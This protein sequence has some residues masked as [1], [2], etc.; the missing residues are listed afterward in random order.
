MHKLNTKIKKND[1][2]DIFITLEIIEVLLTCITQSVGNLEIVTSIIHAFIYG[3]LFIYFILRLYRMFLIKKKPDIELYALIAFAVIAFVAVFINHYSARDSIVWSF[4]SVRPFVL[5]VSTLLLMYIASN[6][7]TSLKTLKNIIFAVG[8]VSLVYCVMYVFFHDS[9]FYWKDNVSN[10][11]TF[12]IV[13]PNRTAIMLFLFFV[14]LFVGVLITRNFVIR[15]IYALLSLVMLF[16]VYKTR[17][18]TMLITVAF[19]VCMFVFAMLKR[20]PKIS[21]IVWIIVAFIPILFLSAYMLIVDNDVFNDVFSFMV[22]VGKGLQS[23]KLVWQETLEYI[24]NSPLLGDCYAVNNNLVSATNTHNTHLHVIA[25]YGLISYIP[26][27]FINCYTF[28]KINKGVCNR[29][30]LC[31]MIAVASVLTSGIAENTIFSAST[32]LFIFIGVFIAMIP[33]ME[34]LPQWN[35]YEKRRIKKH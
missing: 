24:K 8:V 34:E 16:F 14:T 2:F 25:S 32:G 20:K 9:A 5:T 28:I 19:F 17:S 30:K 26:F 11:L 29:A 23:R 3:E 4:G 13:N 27:I 18:R 31:S 10:Y 12:G 35:N 22:S 1:F 21:N 6:S 15:L 7:K 33:T